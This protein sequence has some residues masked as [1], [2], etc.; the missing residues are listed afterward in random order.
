MHNATFVAI[1][2]GGRHVSNTCGGF[3]SKEAANRWLTKTVQNRLI[4]TRVVRFWY[5]LDEHECQE[6]TP[7]EVQEVFFSKEPTK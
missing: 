5:M 4:G 6:Y 7:G 2:I 1:L 3:R